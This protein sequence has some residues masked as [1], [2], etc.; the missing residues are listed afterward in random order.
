MSKSVPPPPAAPKPSA[1]YKSGQARLKMEKTVF[2]VVKGCGPCLAAEKGG[3]FQNP[4]IQKTY[5]PTGPMQTI[6]IDAAGPFKTGSTIFYLVYCIDHFSKFL[7]MG[8]VPNK[9]P[10]H[11][12]NFMFDRIFTKFGIPS[13]SII[14]DNG[15][16][17]NSKLTN[18]MLQK[19]GVHRYFS[20]VYH[21]QGN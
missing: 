16:D 6:S 19:M 14:S 5:I 7:W 10:I 12:F 13:D 21:A 15:M 20:S 18:M 17:V 11:L 2:K 9:K 8:K 4:P 1:F 3:T